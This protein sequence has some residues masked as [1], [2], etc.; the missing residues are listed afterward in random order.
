MSTFLIASSIG[1]G[2]VVFGFIATFA[3]FVPTSFSDADRWPLHFLG[4]VSGVDS[5]TSEGKDVREPGAEIPVTEQVLE[6]LEALKLIRREHACV[7]PRPAI[8]R[9]A[10]QEISVTSKKE[11]HEG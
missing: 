1:F 10:L 6:R 8:A 2:S 11:D 4:K 9:Y 5:E 7:I 3:Y